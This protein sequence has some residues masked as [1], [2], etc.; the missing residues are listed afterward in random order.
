MRAWLTQFSLKTRLITLISL[1]C[2]LLVLL[3]GAALNGMR[4]SNS[5]L[6]HLYTENLLPS[7]NLSRIINDMHHARTQLLLALQHRPGSEYENA[8]NHHVSMHFDAV[9]TSLQNLDALLKRYLTT[10]MHADQQALADQLQRSLHNYMNTGVK[11]TLQAMRQNDYL[12][13]NGTLL[14]QLQPTFSI[15]YDLA[16]QLTQFQQDHARE[17]YE[18]AEQKFERLLMMLGSALAVVLAVV[19]WLAWATVWS[20]SHAVTQ[21][22]RG[23]RQL[24][25]GDLRHRVNYSGRDELGKIAV[26]FNG[27]AGRMQRTIQEL[28]AAVDQLAA[29]ALQ[30]SAVS[31]HTSEGIHRQH[32][33]TDQVATAMH[34]MSATVQ[35]VAGN[36]ANAAHA[37]EHADQQATR[38]K[39]VVAQS[40]AAIDSLARE[41]EHAAV[42]IHEL[43]ENSATISSVVDVIR[44]IAEQT[45]LLALNAAIEAARAG[46][47]GRGFAVVA[48]EVRSLA[49]RT[50]QSTQ[51]IQVMIEKLQTGARN[52]VNVMQ[53]SCSKAQIG[54][55]QVTGAGQM[56]DQITAAV[57]TINDMNAMIA[58]AAEEQS[59]VAEEIN[60]N[61]T[62]VSDIAEDTSEAAR[63]NVETSKQLSELA[64]H[65]Q[66]LAQGFKL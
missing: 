22:Q 42:V 23:G 53:S 45:N 17:A 61:I 14:V 32:L 47:Q 30:T 36:A 6:G 57:A 63:Q 2:V 40:I 11:P 54:R 9:E 35:D 28:A 52:A 19:I 51:E 34:E 15:A 18:E 12:G 50:Q 25:N 24:A 37:A 5:E 33:E 29:A 16:R 3:V 8:H 26:A 44:G 38:G 55:E 46:E 43:E 1:L 49:S 39:Q 4:I 64:N 13:A 10:P 20:I 56:L 41:V 48:D 21:L 27:M 65:L 7:D 62:N 59:S 60:R 58:S 66:K 31:S